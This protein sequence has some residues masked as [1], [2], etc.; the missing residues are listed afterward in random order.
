MMRKTQNGG[1][2]IVGREA[3]KYASSCMRIFL[4]STVFLLISGRWWG[5]QGG[6][7]MKGGKS[8]SKI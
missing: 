7:V 6:F 4:F 2:E 8:I 3:K 1:W 5:K